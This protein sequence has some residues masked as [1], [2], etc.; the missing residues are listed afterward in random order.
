[1]AQACRPAIIFIPKPGRLESP[2]RIGPQYL[3][4]LRA[5]ST[6]LITTLEPADEGDVD[7]AWEKEVAARSK[8]VQEGRVVPVPADEALARVRRSLKPHFAL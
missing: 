3:P 5:A 1:V 2:P 8:D 6:T 4:T 7:P